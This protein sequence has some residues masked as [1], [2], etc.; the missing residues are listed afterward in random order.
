MN[1]L[2][3]AFGGVRFLRYLSASLTVDT[4]ITHHRIRSSRRM[5]EDV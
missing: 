1:D 4:R 5:E 3:V 2:D